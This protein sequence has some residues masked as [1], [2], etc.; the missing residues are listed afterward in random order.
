MAVWKCMGSR[1]LDED[2]KPICDHQ[3]EK[4]WRGRCPKCKRPFECRPF[5]IQHIVK[6]VHEVTAAQ[7]TNPDLKPKYIPSGVK[8]FDHVLGGGLCESQIVLFGGPPGSRKTSLSLLVEDGIARETRST[9]AY[10]SAEQNDQDVLRLC[11]LVGI[12]SPKMKIRGS[13]HSCHLDDTIEYLR[14]VQPA[15]AV[16]DSLQAYASQSGCSM[17][18]WAERIMHFTK[19]TKMIV[20]IVGHLTLELTFKGGTG[21]PYYV[22]TM[23]MFEPFFPNQDGNPVELFGRRVAAEIGYE[24]VDDQEL[25]RVRVLVGGAFGKNRFGPI[26]E[27]AYYYTPKDGALRQLEPRTKVLLFPERDSES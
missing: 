1:R 13:N 11:Q 4:P 20:I 8:G 27:K 19:G 16:L 14:E 22:D 26:N 6:G 9:V 18:T 17:E 24:G 7:S 15:M 23:V 10:L 21:P 5:G 12:T 2:G 25:V 3:A